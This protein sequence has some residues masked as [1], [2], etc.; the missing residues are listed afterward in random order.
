MFISAC[1]LA[2]NEEKYIG[3]CLESIKSLADEIIVLDTGSTDNTK[4]IA[5]KYAKVF[6]YQWE[7]DFSKA[8][9]RLINMAKG[10]WI[11]FIDA[12]EILK[13]SAEKIKEYIKNTDSKI[14]NFKVINNDVNKTIK[15]IFYR[16]YIFKNKLGFK[17]KYPVHEQLDIINKEKIDTRNDFIIEI[18]KED[19]SLED[20]RNKLINYSKSINEYL[21]K[22]NKVSELVY[23]YPYLGDIESVFSNYQNALDL[24]I[25]TYNLYY[26][27]NLNKN[28]I[29]YSNLLYRIVQNM[30]L[31]QHLY[32]EATPFMDELLKVCPDLPD[33][34]FFLA[35]SNQ[36]LRNYLPTLKLY[37][38]I[39]RII[40]K[41]EKEYFTISDFGDNL[42]NIVKVEMARIHD[43]IGENDKALSIFKE[44]Y[45]EDN[46]LPDVLFQL[47]R[48]NLIND[49]IISCIPL[50]KE[51]NNIFELKGIEQLEQISKLSKKDIRYITLE[52][53]LLD[54]LNS[55]NGWQYEE[56]MQIEEK[57]ESLKLLI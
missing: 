31:Y 11:F 40:E 52:L 14:I 46:S 51:K 21:S 9:N 38:K 13:T 45:N 33:G 56:K 47:I 18:Q 43:I 41:K 44:V 4:K 20:R 54:N 49:D 55:F 29:S 10:E 50:F 12:D 16:T 35:F 22:N 27:N 30:V 57:I 6:T 7:N 24:Y 48:I 2:K 8:R 32:N 5:S 17:Y 37:R 42:K 25:K 23:Y 19:L 15:P 39:L 34:L 3:N 1:I 53:K 36:K 26:E 28:T